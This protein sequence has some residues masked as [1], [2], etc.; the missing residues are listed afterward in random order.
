[1]INVIQLLLIDIPG[2][3]DSDNNKTGKKTAGYIMEDANSSLNML[4]AEGLT[5]CSLCA[6]LSHLIEL[7]RNAFEIR[8]KRD[9]SSL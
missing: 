9:N 2:H 3:F 5:F 8:K 7:T 1:M 4:T 6:T